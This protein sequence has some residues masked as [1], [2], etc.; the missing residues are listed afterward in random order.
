M[1]CTTTEQISITSPPGPRP[2]PPRGRICSVA[3]HLVPRQHQCVWPTL[4]LPAPPPLPRTWPPATL[5]WDTST[6][7]TNTTRPHHT[8]PLITTPHPPHHTT[9]HHTTPLRSGAH[10]Q[11]HC[12]CATA[13][14]R[15]RNCAV[16]LRSGAHAQW[17]CAPCAAP[18]RSC[19]CAV[20][21][22][23]SCAVAHAQWCCAC[24]PLRSGACTTARKWPIT[25]ANPSSRSQLVGDQSNTLRI[26]LA[27]IGGADIEESK[28]GRIN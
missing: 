12:A 19:A 4:P 6:D 28:R 13:Q 16:V 17:C 21:Q 24:A 18:L 3:N 26:M 1:F 14:L 5:H 25:W 7:N 22:L 2:R 27:M 8:T 23:R 9:P 11:H 10:A 20:A 15:M